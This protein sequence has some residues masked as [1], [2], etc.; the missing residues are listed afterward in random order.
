MSRKA[1][2][3]YVAPAGAQLGWWRP[4]L[5]MVII[6]GCWI[7]GTIFVVFGWLALRWLTLGDLHQ[8]VQNLNNFGKAGG[9]ETAIV[10]LMTF[11]GI[12]AGVAIAA[13]SLHNQRFAT[14]FSPPRALP[15]TASRAFMRGA[16]LAV[17][18]SGV[19]L[20]L[21]SATVGL[22]ARSL[23]FGPWILALLP[24][25]GLVFIQAT[26]EELIFRGYL[27]Q[28]LAV[29]FRSPLVWAVIPSV[30]FGLLHAGNAEGV[31]AL[32]YMAITGIT[33]CTLAVVVWR[34]G[35]LWAAVGMHVFVNV[36]SLT[37]VGAEGV[38]SGTQLWLY[39]AEALI[40]LLQ[41]DIATSAILLILVLSPFGGWVLGSPSAVVS[42]ESRDPV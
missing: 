12:W 29:R 14:L 15:G 10:S 16:V 3:D 13:G 36:I 24:L 39:P 8:A 42:G 23:E 25:V 28:Q 17:A 21:A 32:Y 40:P 9:T 7:I 5:G 20:V 27:M 30:L 2:E 11:V 26:G 37:G 35:T 19:S 6:M 18:F 1:F 41:V 38:L 4:L 22:P 31:A 33:G 34:T